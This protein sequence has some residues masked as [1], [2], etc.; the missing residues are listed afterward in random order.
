MGKDYVIQHYTIVWFIGSW[1]H[2]RISKF[3]EIFFDKNK[4]YDFSF[5]QLFYSVRLINEFTNLAA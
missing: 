1:K 4:D 2:F 5:P 3:H